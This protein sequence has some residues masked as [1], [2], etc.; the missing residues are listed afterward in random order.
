LNQTASALC[1]EGFV[2]SSALLTEL[3]DLLETDSIWSPGSRASIIKL[4]HLSAYYSSASDTESIGSDF[5]RLSVKTDSLVFG[6]ETSISEPPKKVV[7]AFNSNQNCKDEVDCE[8]K[9]N[10]SLEAAIDAHEASSAL[11]AFSERLTIPRSFGTLLSF[12]LSSTVS[13]SNLPSS[14]SQ[15][16]TSGPS[17]SPVTIRSWPRSGFSSKI[18]RPLAQIFKKRASS[19]Q[20]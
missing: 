14:I 2:D 17:L 10:S 15:S 7:E 19:D 8:Q 13:P 9:D 5:G 3:L 20:L 1:S 16:F 6:E 4:Y 12:D 11:P 18:K